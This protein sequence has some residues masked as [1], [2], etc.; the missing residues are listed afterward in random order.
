M[1]MQKGNEPTAMV[2]SWAFYLDW[3]G[4]AIFTPEWLQYIQQR[5][6]LRSIHNIAPRPRSRVVSATHSTNLLQPVRVLVHVRRGDII[7][8]WTNLYLP[9]SHYLQILETY[10]SDTNVFYDVTIYSESS[11]FEP[12]H[13]FNCSTI[14][15]HRRQNMRCHF[16][17]DDDIV[18]VWSDMLGYGQGDGR[19]ILIL[20]RS[21]FSFVPALLANPLTTT[22]I[23]TP[24]HQYNPLSHW[25]VVNDLIMNKTEK[26][27]RGMQL[28]YMSKTEKGNEA[29]R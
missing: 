13:E 24:F 26:I 6:K 25:T 29:T 2:I 19:R 23:Y 21:T 5:R 10:L 11:S 20:S 17:F 1:E 14:S 28:E 18:D 27:S 16:S 9:N 22:V 7:P 3:K 15:H 8:Q 12:W 4:T